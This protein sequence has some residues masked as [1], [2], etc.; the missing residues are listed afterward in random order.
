MKVIDLTPRGYCHGVL[1]ALAIVKKVIKNES[2]P[3]PIYVL[4]QIVHNK[5][6]TEAFRHFGVISLDQPGK[7]RMEMLEEVNEGTVI[8]TAHGI[9]DQVI[10]KAKEKGLTYMNATCRDVYRVHKAVKDKLALGYKIIYI[11]H[12]NHPEPEAILAID[13]SIYFV[14][15]EKDA[16]LLPDYLKDEKVFVTN[17][18]TLAM[19]DIDSV[20]KII[21][22]KYPDYLFDNEICNAT[23]VRQDAVINQEKVDL[24]LVVGDEKSSNSN[25][26]A[27]VGAHHQNIPSHLIGGI[28]DIDLNWLNGIS[29]V[30]VTSGASTPTSVTNEVIE[31]LKQYKKDDPK[32]WDHTSKLDILDIL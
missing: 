16:L 2:Y 6:I 13:P 17:Q 30:S 18:T 28:E 20:L 10:E 3:R 1:N 7:T 23:T 21:E 19:Y 29:S 24:M 8:F 9:S 5:K 11:G 32:T 31:F 4:G 14:E 26:L 15:D 22:T 25:K 27:F 12:R